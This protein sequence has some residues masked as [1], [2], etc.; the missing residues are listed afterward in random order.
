[1]PFGGLLVVFF[2]FSRA[3][4][5]TLR[6]QCPGSLCERLVVAASELVLWENR[7]CV[8]VQLASPH[9]HDVAL[10]WP[11]YGYKLNGHLMEKPFI[12]G[13]KRVPPPLVLSISSG[14]WRPYCASSQGLG[15][16]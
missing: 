11:V 7:C 15:S 3:A 13:T 8:V 1:M 10:A 16:I 6:G 4:D 12:L 9:S 5:L 2:C 14:G